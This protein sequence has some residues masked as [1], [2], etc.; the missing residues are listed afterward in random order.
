MAAFPRSRL[1][2]SHEG[3]RAGSSDLVLVHE[4]R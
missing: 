2:L 4:I 1:V 3:H